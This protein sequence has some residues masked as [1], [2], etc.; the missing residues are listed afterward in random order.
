MPNF[1]YHIPEF[2]LISVIVKLILLFTMVSSVE[3]K[4][5]LTIPTILCGLNL[6]IINILTDL[7]RLY[8]RLK[9]LATMLKMF[10]GC[11]IL[12]ILNEN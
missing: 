1:I 8:Y 10:Y 9:K 11:F 5:T 7:Q 2:H 4:Y 3:L 12:I 6:Q